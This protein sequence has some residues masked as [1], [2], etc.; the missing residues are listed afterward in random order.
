MADEKVLTAQ[1]WVNATY[2]GVTGYVRCAEDGRT[3][4]GT[5]QALTMALQHE[6]GI[7]PVVASFGPTTLSRLE[8]LGPLHV[9]WAE[10][11]GIARILKHALFCKGYWGGNYDT[12]EVEPV[13]GDAINEMKFQMGLPTDTLVQARV[14]K[15]VLNMDAYVRAGDGSDAVR[16]VQ[17]WLNGRYWQRSAYSIGP[18]D[19]RYSRD[20]QKALMVALQYEMGVPSPNGNFGEGTQAA[21]R[22]HPV[23]QGDS[24]VITQLFSAG[25]VFNSPLPAGATAEFTDVYDSELASWVAQFQDFSL[26]ERGEGDYR[27]W[28][29]LLVSMG[30]PDRPVTGSDTRFEITPVRA[31]WLADRKFEVVGRY[32]Y[33]PPGSTLDKEIKPGELDVIFA[34]GLKVFPIFQANARTLGDFTTMQ[35]Y[36]HGALAHDLARE[37]GFNWGTVIYFAVDY[38]ATQAEIDSAI[39]PYFQGVATALEQRGG[40]YRHGVYGSRNVCANVSERTGAKYSFVSGMSWGFS[41]NLGYPLPANWSFNQIQET[42]VTNGT[43]VFDLD[44][45]AVS[46]RDRASGSVNQPAE[47]YDGFIAAIEDLYALAVQYGKGDP[48]QLVMEFVRHDAYGGLDWAYLIGNYDKDFVAYA[49]AR[50]MTVPKQFVDPFTG[51]HLGAEHLL[52]TANGVFVHP[53]ADNRRSANSG[54]ITGWGGDLI[55]LYADW[56]DA[57]DTYPDGRDFVNENMANPEVPTTFGYSDFI[58]DVDGYLIAQECRSSRDIVTAIRGHYENGGGRSRFTSFWD[59]RFTGNAGEAGYAVQNVLTA[60]QEPLT[61]ARLGLLGRRGITTLPAMLPYSEL[62]AFCL[63]FLDVLQG[64]VNGES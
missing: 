48:D 57:T 24:G 18:C 33:D 52:A 45:D 19:G 8:A 50:D 17:Q 10:N 9:A 20:V 53:P 27:T 39:V 32:L 56:R 29:Q 47:Q 1:R 16:Q 26:L 28:C 25:C 61:V 41:G 7:S 2:S 12:G 5:M 49:E 46:S 23:G 64:R 15:C 31:R 55:T 3:G 22:D 42:S 40:R 51:T 11:A 60:E 37:Y 21:L 14:F 4:W 30:D 59:S 62:E 54:D 38:D 34:A 43:D 35:G 6:L 58:E 63:G 13:T 36:A 44:R